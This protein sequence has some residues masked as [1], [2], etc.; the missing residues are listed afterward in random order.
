[1]A[2]TCRWITRSESWQF[3]DS[4]YRNGPV[5]RD[6]GL[7]Q[8]FQQQGLLDI[9]HGP[10]TNLI[11]R[12]EEV[13]LVVRLDIDTLTD[14]CEKYERLAGEEDVGVE[15]S[16]TIKSS[17]SRF[18]VKVRQMIKGMEVSISNFSHYRHM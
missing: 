7:W 4:R 9:T 3:E 17:V 18:V 13:L 16:T 10:L 14:V 6:Q 2:K 11:G 5:T 15:F 8:E 1:M 12:L